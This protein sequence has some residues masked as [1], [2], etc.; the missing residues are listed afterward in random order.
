M[1][2]VKTQTNDFLEKEAVGK[3]MLRYAVPCVISLLVAAFYNI[4]DQI[5]IANADYLGSYGNSA[6]SIVYP[7]T[8]VALAIATMIGDGCCAVVS[9]SLG[10]KDNDNAGKCVGNT[11]M[12]LIVSSLVLTA[13]YLV[14]NEQI[15][16]L[17]GARVNDETFR[18]SKEY[19]LWISI[20]IPFYM[21]GQ[22][23]SPVIRS[24]GSPRFAMIVLLAGAIW[25]IIFDPICIYVLRW[26]M[27][28]AAVATISGQILSAVLSFAYLFK[29]KA[30]KLD[31]KSFAF[32]GDLL[33]KMLPL[34]ITSFLSQIS[35]V[36]SLAAVNNMLKE[37]GAMDPIF[38]Q[39][40]YSQIPTAVM[41]ISIKFYQIA[42]SIAIGLSAGCIPVI[43]YNMGAQR[44]DRVL[45]LM[46]RLISSELIVGLIASIIF[47]VFPR[48]LTNIFGGR[49]EGQYYIDF[50]IRCLRTLLCLLP[51][52]C[53]N[54]GTFIMLQSLGKAMQSTALSLIREIVFGVGLPIILPM[55]MGLYGI[56]YFT[57]GADLI[58]FFFS[59]AAI[60]L[61]VKELKSP[62][63]KGTEEKHSATENKQTAALTDKVITIGRSY[64]AGGRTVG[65][66]LAE[67][68][69]IPYYDSVLLEKA[70][71]TAGLD[72]KFLSG[73]DEKP[74]KY[75]QYRGLSSDYAN[76]EM[77]A[78][79]AQREIIER[80]AESPCVIVGRRSD[81][82]LK[83]RPNTL[84]VFITAS[85]ETR[86]KRISERDRLT[87]K[88]SE[89]KI[90]RIDKERASYYNQNSKNKWGQAST[91]D[92]CIDTDK[93]GIQ[94]AADLLI[95]MLS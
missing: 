56:A 22:G 50:S 24:D 53:L 40:A 91:Y 90:K 17:F 16:T 61:N 23:M 37:Y 66:I 33:K 60:A 25:N 6:N 14:F 71:E 30:V 73:R 85:T 43:G 77:Q 3:L 42:I 11:V 15:M 74:G 94:G 79:Q 47:L 68:L 32:R 58:T 70:A 82:I 4:V 31:K 78:A 57:P 9:I 87:V 76:I 81:Q 26:G 35:I 62:A 45:G 10:A 64:G 19:F 65:K 83:D 88:D 75:Y 28:G 67:N 63:A 86:A 20:G 55:F 5:F 13:I 44:N 41:G 72:K 52:S 69:G 54:K 34:G 59:A 80:V 93:F 2:D 49:T 39:A 48:Q 29:M 8:V 36:F 21:F 18:L 92:I 84:N 12:S 7:L 51:L 38:S 46:K 89:K 1:N 27:M 95:S